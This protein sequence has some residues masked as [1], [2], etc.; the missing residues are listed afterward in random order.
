MHRVVIAGACLVGLCGCVPTNVSNPI[1]LAS[2][3]ELMVYARA[4]GKVATPGKVQQETAICQGHVSA[5]AIDAPKVSTDQKGAVG[6]LDIGMQVIDR[7][8]TVN[9]M[10]RSCMAERGYIL[11]PRSQAPV[12][13]VHTA[14]K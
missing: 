13:K 7:Q 3:S 1:A 9:A 2:D 12:A 4:D 5:A 6:I 8:Q 14:V 11:V 10:E